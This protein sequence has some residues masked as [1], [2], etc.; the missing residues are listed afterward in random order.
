MVRRDPPD[1]AR[2]RR[3]QR[4]E[5]LAARADD[6]CLGQLSLGR[7]E[8]GLRLPQRVQLGFKGS[9]DLSRL[10][11]VAELS[12]AF[13]KPPGNSKRKDH[14]VLGSM[15]PVNVSGTPDWHFSTVAVRTGRASGTAVSAPF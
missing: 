11:P 8:A 5:P 12:L 14:C 2:W 4:P 10:H 3:G 9:E 7:R 13:Q 15:R 6:A 1:K